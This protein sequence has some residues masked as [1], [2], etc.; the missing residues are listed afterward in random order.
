[1]Y[2]LRY[3]Q[4]E[5]K[6]S[7]FDY[8]DKQT[9]NPVIA[10]PTGTGK[11]VVIASFIIDVLRQWPNQRFLMLTHVKELIEQNAKC[12]LRMWGQAPLGFYSSGLKRRDTWHPILFAGVQSVSPAIRNN[13]NFGHRDLLII[14][15]CH[16]LSDKQSSQYQY[17]IAKL[18]K[19]NPLMKVIGFTATPYRMK[20]GKLT[21]NGIFTDICYDITSLDSFNRLIAEGFLSPLVARK[22]DTEI[23][24][25]SVNVIG[26]EYNSKQL[27]KAVDTDVIVMSAVK[28]SIA[29]ANDRRSWLVFATGIDNTEHVA[30]TF[31]LFGMDIL[32]VHSKLPDNV[33]TER[34]NAFRAGELRGIVSGQKLTT[35][36]DHPPIDFIADL[37]PTLSAG[38]HVQ[39][40]GRGTRPAPG[41]TNCLC[42]DFGGNIRR[43]GPIN[44]PRIPTG[45]GKLR[46][47]GE[48]PVRICE[49]CGIYNH[50]R[51]LMC[52][53]CGTL[54]QIESK[55]STTSTTLQPLRY[56]EPEIEYFNVQSVTYNVYRKKDKPPMI[57][58]TYFCGI[59]KFDEYVMI[60]HHGHPG[61]R[62]R[63]WWKARHSGPCP[64]TTFKALERISE[65]KTPKRVKVQ[66]NLQYPVI[67]GWE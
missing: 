34:L 28:E 7:L 35:G 29:L 46:G 56:S 43:L 39:K 26:G 53:G 52:Q 4:H 22:T 65:L 48:M 33:N 40:L 60:E 32:P 10:M 8:F 24:L 21:E 64:P 16:L 2:E 38:K 13:T 50:A 31:R 11:S 19:V 27:E 12:L 51:S 18:L 49:S 67:L 5:A 23:N 20:T 3:Y 1:M 45:G 14:D 17:V 37:N 58:A 36:F 6:Q 61:E 54:F 63:Q 59:R 66:T 44:D 15:E 42:A 9:G 62:A 47:N 57:K 25:D 41:K 55:L 30:E